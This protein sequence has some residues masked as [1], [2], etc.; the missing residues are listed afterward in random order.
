MLAVQQVLEQMSVFSAFSHYVCR[1][2]I[3]LPPTF[4]DRNGKSPQMKVPQHRNPAV[5]DKPAVEHSIDFLV[6]DCTNVSF[7]PRLDALQRHKMTVIIVNMLLNKTCFLSGLA[8][9]DNGAEMIVWL[10]CLLESCLLR[11]ESS[12]V[13]ASSGTPRL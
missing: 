9:V 11:L 13:C 5:S 2:C 12:K 10:W 1:V 8:S 6:P 4:S 3:S 7:S